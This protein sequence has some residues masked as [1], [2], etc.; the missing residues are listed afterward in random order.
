VSHKGGTLYKAKKCAKHDRELTWNKQGPQ[1]RQGVQ[2]VQGMPGSGPQGPPGPT[3]SAYGE[4]TTDTAL[5]GAAP[6]VV[7]LGQ[8]QSSQTPT[9][10]TISV[11]YPARLISNAGVELTAN[12]TGGDV[13]CFLEYAPVG[14]SY[15]QMSAAPAELD[16][17]SAVLALSVLGSADVGPGVYDVRVRCAKTGTNAS[18]TEAQLSVIAT[19]R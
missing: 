5:S 14:G 4:A 2:G 3:A 8:A 13:W 1:G 19:A 18:A 7:A 6:V 11:S 10:G 16:S 17:A 9:T 15:V 12:P